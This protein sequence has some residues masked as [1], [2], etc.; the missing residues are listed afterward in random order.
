MNTPQTDVHVER[1]LRLRDVMTMTALGSSTIYRK[2]AEGVFPRPLELSP[3]CVR[4]RL[5]DVR[6]WIDQLPAAQARAVAA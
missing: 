1:L 4:W 6:R 5:S 2:M 3:A